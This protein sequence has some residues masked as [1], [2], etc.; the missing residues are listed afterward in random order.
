MFFFHFLIYLW[1]LHGSAVFVLFSVAMW[2]QWSEE[3]TQRKH[4]H[5]GAYV[6]LALGK[7]WELIFSPL[8][9]YEEC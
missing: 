9:K 2:L 4:R 3:M 7:R 6:T 8:C 1:P 5:L